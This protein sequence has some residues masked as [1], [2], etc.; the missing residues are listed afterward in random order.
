MDK[1][2]KKQVFLLALYWYFISI[3]VYSQDIFPL[4]KTGLFVAKFTKQ[5]LLTIW[6]QLFFSTPKF[7]HCVITDACA[8][9]ETYT[10]I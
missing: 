5:V 7:G 8:Y 9:V 4:Q 3:I 6:F 2:P 1:G 10:A